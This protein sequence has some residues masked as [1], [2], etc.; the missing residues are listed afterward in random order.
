M[1]G[2]FFYRVFAG[3][4]IFISI[5]L[6]MGCNPHHVAMEVSPIIDGNNAYSM[7]IEG[8]EPEGRWWEA[9][10]DSFLDTIIVEALSKNLTLAQSRSRI[11]QAMATD[12][13]AASF[14]F[15]EVTGRASGEA[16]WT[17]GDK[18]EETYTAGASLS[19]EIDLWKRLSS[20]RKAAALEILASR[21]ELEAAALFLT[22]RIAETYFEIIE[23][24][25]Q[26]QL[27]E[28]QIAAG[29]TLLELIELRFGYGEASVVDV[30][31]QRQ[32]LAATRARGPVVNSR[33]RTLE[34]RLSVQL[35]RAPMSK[36]IG[37]A[38]NLPK[39][40]S[41]PTT[42]VPID[43]LNNRPDLKQIYNKLLAIDFRVAEAVAD[44]FPKIELNG[45]ALYKDSLS[46]E[47]MLY[48]ILLKAAA[49]IFDRERRS[50]KV[51]LREAEFREELARYS[52]AY[53]TAM[54][55]VETALWQEHYQQDLLKALD[56]QISIARS[57]LAETRNRYQQGL[58]DYLPV[59]TALHS[60]Q[61]LE[62]DILTNKRELISLHIL[63]YRSLGGST[64]I[65][66]VANTAPKVK[67]EKAQ[68]SEGV[69]Q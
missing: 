22:S 12:T 14:L 9:L 60:L 49:P 43:L 66:H 13:I 69:A 10:N 23:Q 48:S 59:L 15:P 26:L 8:F 47:G 20:A 65:A 31:Q 41:L 35:G 16:G 51:K 38:D 27:L 5:P 45:S 2:R 55:E 42:G 39:L 30:Y 19:W 63:L 11:E 61:Q 52:E 32:L 18:S 57:N 4:A 62:R 33:L 21:E 54:E 40:S 28:R 44:R 6:A 37:I 1:I 53:L 67:I 64:L 50:S 7:S 24:N 34:N 25:L 36:P 3:V 29:E 17:D 58:T 56:E 46:T 68:T